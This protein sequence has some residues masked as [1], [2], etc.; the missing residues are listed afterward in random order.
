MCGIRGPRCCPWEDQPKVFKALWPL[1]QVHRTL[2]W[3]GPRSL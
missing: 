3:R 1:K 2:A